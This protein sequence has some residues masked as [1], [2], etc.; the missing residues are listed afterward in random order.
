MIKTLILNVE[1]LN[2]KQDAERIVEHFQ[3]MPGIE[4]IEVDLKVNLVILKYQDEHVSH[5]KRFLDDLNE[6]GYTV[7]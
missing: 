5:T 4:K 3:F 6:L 7:K 2:S 1:N